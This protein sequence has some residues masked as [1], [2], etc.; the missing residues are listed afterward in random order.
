MISRAPQ[1]VCDSILLSLHGPNL[2][3]LTP[4]NDVTNILLP[5]ECGDEITYTERVTGSMIQRYSRP[6]LIHIDL[7]Q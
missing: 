2:C 6:L 3:M 7:C 1:N 4:P 5:L